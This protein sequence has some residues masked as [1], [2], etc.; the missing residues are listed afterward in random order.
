MTPEQEK[1]ENPVSG[2]KVPEALTVRR[3]TAAENDAPKMEKPEISWIEYSAGDPCR[4][5]QPEDIC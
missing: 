4:A 2:T 3:L 5:L 1:Q